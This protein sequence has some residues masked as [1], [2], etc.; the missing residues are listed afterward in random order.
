MFL[1][2]PA[3]D[4][5]KRFCRVR[6]GV[7][8]IPTEQVG[9]ER[10][11]HF[12]VGDGSWSINRPMFYALRSPNKLNIFPP[13]P[14]VVSMVT[15]W[16]TC[17]HFSC[18]SLPEKDSLASLYTVDLLN[19]M[20]TNPLVLITAWSFSLG[21]NPCQLQMVLDTFHVNIHAQLP[22]ISLSNI[23]AVCYCM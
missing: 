2:I 12:S 4:F 9:T 10:E 15:R 14:S 3:L 20:S 17:I 22:Y 1:K 7:T 18:F 21:R 23:K 11:K 16:E 6:W 13:L 5:L 8:H 19:L